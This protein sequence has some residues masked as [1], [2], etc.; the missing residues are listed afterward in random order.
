MDTKVIVCNYSFHTAPTVQKSRMLKCYLFRLQTE[1]SCSALVDG[2]LTKIGPKDLL[3]YKPGDLYELRIGEDKGEPVASGDYFVIC[4]GSWLDEWWAMKNRPRL[5]HLQDI[6]RLLPIWR[7]LVLQKRAHMDNSNKLLDYLVRSLCL[8][9]DQTAGV[10]IPASRRQYTA[11]RMKKY[12]KERAFEPFVIKEVADHVKLSVSRATHLFKEYYGKS[13]IQ[14]ATEIRLMNAVDKMV[15][16]NMTL[17]QIA[18]SSGFLSYPYFYKAFTKQYG[19][20]PSSYLKS[21]M[22]EQTGGS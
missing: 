16:G 8:L 15:Y 14:Y 12:I 6:D 22:A 3:L 7:E 20:S 18:R 5:L 9:I 2:K 17:E 21:I 11:L 13:M 1:S 19:V 4:S 10:S